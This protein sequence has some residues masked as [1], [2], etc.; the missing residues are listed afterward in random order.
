M[1]NPL[2]ASAKAKP[3]E[4]PFMGHAKVWQHVQSMAPDEMQKNL[5]QSSFVT[6]ILA[7]LSSDPKVTR[8]DVI[9]AAADASGSGKVE[10]SQAV[11]FITTMPDD[12][13]KIQPWLKGLFATHLNATVHMKA[14][15]M[16]DQQPQLGMPQ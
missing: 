15:M 11:Q 1:Q 6:P 3:A 10:P 16:P 5:D 9:K 14:A 7:K 13:D 8:K 12:P 2:V 4:H